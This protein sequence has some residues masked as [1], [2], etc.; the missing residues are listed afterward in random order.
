MLVLPALLRG[1][2]QKGRIMSPSP[3]I[4]IRV[5]DF[6]RLGKSVMLAKTELPQAG[7]R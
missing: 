3:K 2:L 5:Y 6:S 7:Y 4:R 1:A